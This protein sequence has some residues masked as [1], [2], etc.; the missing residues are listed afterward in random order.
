MMHYVLQKVPASATQNHWFLRLKL[1][2][3]TALFLCLGLAWSTVQAQSRQVSGKVTE[4]GGG[5]LPGVTVQVKGT[6]N[7]TASDA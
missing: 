1:I 3:I 2:G 7:G 5:A 4:A 6:T